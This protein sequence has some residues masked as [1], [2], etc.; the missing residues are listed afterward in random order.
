MCDEPQEKGKGFG[1]VVCWFYFFFP[2]LSLKFPLSVL[3][4]SLKFVAVRSKM[5]KL[6]AA[7]SE[8]E[9]LKLGITTQKEPVGASGI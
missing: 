6:S 1:A 7:A 9:L 4:L 5:T 2:W 3:W 8:Q